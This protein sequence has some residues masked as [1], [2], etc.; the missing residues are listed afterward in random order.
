MDGEELQVY[1]SPESMHA[2]APHIRLPLFIKVN[3]F[4]PCT[5]LPAR[6]TLGGVHTQ[7]FRRLK[8]FKS[9]MDSVSLATMLLRLT[10]FT[11][12]FVASEYVVC[13]HGSIYSCRTDVRTST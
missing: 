9:N 5:F 13:S 12:V 2:T 7:A 4:P 8:D 1:D 3:M 11:R 10:R 6:G